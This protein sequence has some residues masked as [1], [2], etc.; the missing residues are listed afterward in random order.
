MPKIALRS[1]LRFKQLHVNQ[2]MKINL[3]L[4]CPRE[5]VANKKKFVAKSVYEIRSILFMLIDYS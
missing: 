2:G 3:A 4:A 5:I 1:F